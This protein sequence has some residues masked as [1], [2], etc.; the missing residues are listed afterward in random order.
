VTPSV[1]ASEAALEA[2]RPL[3]R[4]DVRL[5]RFRILEVVCPN[6]HRLAQVF[7]T[8]AGPLVLYR[9]WRHRG[10]LSAYLLD[11]RGGAEWTYTPQ[12]R[13]SRAQVPREWLREQIAAGQRRVVWNGSAV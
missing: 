4:P 5:P 1:R 9:E 7:S 8:A 13:C 10:G 6:D 11:E 2:L 12:C 3:L